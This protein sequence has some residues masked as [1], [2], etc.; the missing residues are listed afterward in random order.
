M[1][2]LCVLNLQ[3][4]L[5]LTTL[6]AISQLAS[7]APDT[8]LG[9]NGASWGSAGNW[10]TANPPNPGDSLIFGSSG[11]GTLINN[12][13]DGTAF[14]GLTFNG[15]ATFTLNGPSSVLLSGQA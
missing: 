14:D 7:A 15:S 5:V 2:R 11:G 6:L 8:W 13:T 9:A 12:L 1:K 3:T 10:D 4:V